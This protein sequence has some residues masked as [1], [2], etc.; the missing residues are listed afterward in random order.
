MNDKDDELDDVRQTLK[1]FDKGELIS[2]WRNG[3]HEE[4]GRREITLT[5]AHQGKGLAHANY[6][7]LDCG[8]KRT[9]LIAK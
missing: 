4:V 1:M 6:H 2:L 3:E 7:I 5:A 9:Y 8:G